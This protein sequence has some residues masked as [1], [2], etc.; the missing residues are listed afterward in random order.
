MKTTSRREVEFQE[1]LEKYM[2][3]Y[4][5]AI[6]AHSKQY[7]RGTSGSRFSSSILKRR[8]RLAEV[9]VDLAGATQP[10]PGS[11]AYVPV[12]V[13]VADTNVHG[14]K[15]TRMRMIVNYE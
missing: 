2:Y 5:K 11:F 6:I 14:R 13:A 8:G 4:R 10:G 15:L 7:R 1:A 9:M 3:G 12:A